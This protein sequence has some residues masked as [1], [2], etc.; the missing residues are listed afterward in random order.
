MWKSI[1]AAASRGFH[2]ERGSPAAAVVFGCL[3]LLACN[4]PPRGTITDDVGRN[5]T[6]PADVRRIV[7]I[8]PNVTEILF[9]IGAGERVIGTDDHS[10]F[11]PRVRRLPKVG[12]MQPN[13]EKIVALQPDVVFASTEGNQ[14]SLGPA[15]AAV[16]I[17]L[18]VVKTDRADQIPEAMERLAALLRVRNREAAAAAVRVGLAKQRRTRTR[19][20]RVLFAVWTDPLYV[21]GRNTFAGDLLAT[22]GAVNAVTAEGWPQYSLESLVARPPDLILYPAKSVTP[23]Q[24]AALRKAAPGLRAEAVAV[25]E[26]RFTRPGPRVVEAA[27]QLNAILD[28][29]ERRRH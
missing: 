1:T 10:D 4:P 15:L 7:A 8:A 28:A 19:P 5:V 14:P 18:Y 20:P 12:G 21:A 25:D 13:I 23:R 22:T 17:P 6:L 3:F 26:N 16:G 2:L 27:A 9:A 29:W 24:I 11:P